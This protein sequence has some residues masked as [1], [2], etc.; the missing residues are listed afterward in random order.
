MT[1]FCWQSAMFSLV[2]LNEHKC[3]WKSKSAPGPH[4][5][6]CLP[7][8]GNSSFL[9]S[10]HTAAL[11]RAQGV[12]CAPPQVFPDAPGQL[13]ALPVVVLANGRTA[14]AAE[15][16]AGALQGNRRCAVQ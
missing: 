2:L 10:I 15:V 11:C 6:R 3:C 4:L 7:V 5:L 12:P 14:S 9:S 1:H 16:L 13:T 8:Q